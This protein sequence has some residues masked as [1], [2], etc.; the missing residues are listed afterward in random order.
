MT[1]A[2]FLIDFIYLNLL[3]ILFFLRR[4]KLGK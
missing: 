3:V 1:C 4:E 2:N